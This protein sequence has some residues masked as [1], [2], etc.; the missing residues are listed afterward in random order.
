[1]FFLF[2]YGHCKIWRGWSYPRIRDPLVGADMLK[3]LQ[4]GAQQTLNSVQDGDTPGSIATTI[5]DDTIIVCS[6]TSC[7]MD[8][9]VQ[10]PAMCHKICNI[11]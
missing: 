9:A 11:I 5:R 2:E 1:M 6:S 7:D 8:L 10:V 4:E 3:Q